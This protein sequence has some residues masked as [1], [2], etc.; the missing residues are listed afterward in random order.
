MSVPD[1][2]GKIRLIHNLTNGPNVDLYL[3]GKQVLYNVVPSKVTD[4]LKVA[5]G[6]R[7]L[8]VTPHREIARITGVQ[9]NVVQGENYDVILGGDARQ[10]Q[11]IG[12]MVIKN[13]KNCPQRGQ[14][15][16]RFVNAGAGLPS[17]DVYVDGPTMIFR[18]VAY[19][20]VGSPVYIPVQAKTYN[21]GLAP[22]GSTDL[23]SKPHSVDLRDG[24]IYTLVATSDPGKVL[25]VKDSADGL[26]YVG[27]SQVRI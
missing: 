6:S 18:N 9:M 15:H 14:A 2:S 8:E 10:A 22:V 26:C 13:D 21:V 7:N 5:P 20:T 12:L 3:D 17:V 23:L 16:V 11:S 25:V 1:L 27:D 24:Q 19:G 4:Y